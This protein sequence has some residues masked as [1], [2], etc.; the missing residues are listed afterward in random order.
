MGEALGYVA[1]AGDTWVA[2]LA[3]ATAALKCQPRD[4]WIGWAPPLQWRRLAL[5]VNNVR[6]CLLPPARPNLASR[7]LALNLRRL[8]ADWEWAH[9]HPVLLAE[10][11]VDP[12]RFRGTC[13][14]AAG[15]A[16]L[17]VT[18]GFAKRNMR[19]V[20]HGHPKTVW[21]RPLRPG[22]VAALTAPFPR[23]CAG[24]R[25]DAPMLD[26]N[27][28]PLQGAGGLLDLLQAVP[29]P[30][31]RRGVRHPVR[32][33]VALAVCAAVA[34]ARS[35]TAI[36]QWA[37]G[38]S[39]EALHRLGATRRTPPSEPTIRRVLQAVDA[40]ALDARLRPW[41]LQGAAPGPARRS[42]STGR[43]CGG[44]MAGARRRRTSSARSSTRTPWWWRRRRCRPPRTRS[45][46]C[47]PS[48][49]PCRSPGPSSRRMRCTLRPRPRASW[50]RRS[51]PTTCSPSRTTRRPSATTSRPSGW[52]LFPPQA[53]TTEKGHG[54]VETRALWARPALNAYLA[55]P[56]VG[57]I[58]YL[59]R[60]T[61]LLLP[62]TTRIETVY[63][64]TSLP[65]AQA[66]PA[67]LLALVR[68]HWTIEHRLHWVRDV[69]FDED[70]SQIRHG[71]GPQG[72]ATLRN[73]AISLL[74][75]AGPPLIAPALRH[76][77]WAG[78]ALIFRL[79][80]IELAATPSRL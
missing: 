20:A 46:R 22:A 68:A 45:P 50:P 34:G 25:E 30:R 69:P 32:T 11:F 49:R 77:R 74:W 13:Y 36:A 14:R 4:A 67:R 65:P 44:A 40:D 53:T 54:R 17:G 33:V 1:M 52:T 75:L 3:W 47:P 57:Q 2:C 26:A 79:L 55:F 58:C 19:Y 56:H 59:R 72:M 21:V 39:A 71:A 23:P 70:R 31:H 24:S 10:T 27:R 42:A 8:S 15:W 60:T 61:T 43:P 35:F 76:A 66:S 80:G 64:V 38:L 48:S 73:L 63:G 12:V 51:G 37:Q 7:V 6:F 5:V 9:G 62:G 78:Q 28:L 41:L 18:R 16:C 29:D